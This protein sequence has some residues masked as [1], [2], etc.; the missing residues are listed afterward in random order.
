MSQPDYNKMAVHWFAKYREIRQELQEV[1]DQAI[2]LESELEAAH[3]KA[4]DI[5]LEFHAQRALVE[6]LRKENA[7]LKAS[8]K[9]MALTTLDQAGEQAR[10]IYKLKGLLKR[11][12]A[13]LGRYSTGDN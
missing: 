13:L 4:V 1:T 7:E 6:D 12:D 5:Y 3:D 10:E 8:L 11:A 2:E 9:S